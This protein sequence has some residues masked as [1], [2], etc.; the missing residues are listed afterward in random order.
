MDSELADTLIDRA[1]KQH[2]PIFPCGD[3]TTLRECFTRDGERLMLWYNT[4]DNSTHMLS[5]E[6]LN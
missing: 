2:S 5:T 3:K 6:I 4:H 1:T